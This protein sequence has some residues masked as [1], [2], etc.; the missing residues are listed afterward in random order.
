MSRLEIINHTNINTAE[1]SKPDT[2]SSIWFSAEPVA[3]K[4]C[5]C[6]NLYALRNLARNTN[7]LASCSK[8]FTYE[9]DIKV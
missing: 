7:T 1:L 5:H 3:L 6:Y 2:D 4:M 9:T 8:I